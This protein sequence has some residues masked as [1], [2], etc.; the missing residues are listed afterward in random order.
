V[1]TV[2]AIERYL[3]RVDRSAGPRLAAEALIAIAACGHRRGYPRHWMQGTAAQPGTSFVY[4]ASAPGVCLVMRR[5]VVVTV[6]SRASCRAW[7]ERNDQYS[8]VPVVRSGDPHRTL[9]GLA[10]EEAA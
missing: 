2:H 9:E 8:R 5:N 6:F 7:R 3:E 10:V 4:A 1:V